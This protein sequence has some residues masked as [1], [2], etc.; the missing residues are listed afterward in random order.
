MRPEFRG[1][2]STE[3][4][5][6]VSKAAIRGNGHRKVLLI[7]RTSAVLRSNSSCF[8]QP[9]SLSLILFHKIP[10]DKPK[11][12]NVNP[13][14]FARGPFIH[15]LFHNS[16]LRSSSL[17]SYIMFQ[18]NFSIRTLQGPMTFKV[19]HA[20]I[21]L[22]NLPFHPPQDKRES[23]WR[24]VCFLQQIKVASLLASNLHILNCT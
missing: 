20:F 9:I 2:T 12:S 16:P 4:V 11:Y 8:T 18:H 17:R 15:S 19:R 14:E 24:N 10:F 13:S 21:T 1:K 23:S 7:F 22:S 5:P 6:L 3:R